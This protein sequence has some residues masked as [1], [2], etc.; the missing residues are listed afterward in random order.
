MK[1][2]NTLKIVG[3]V[4]LVGALAAFAVLNGNQSGN[5]TFLADKID[6]EVKTAFNDFINKHS[7]NFL[8]KSEYNAR[9]S[10]F[11]N[12][13]EDVKLHNAQNSSFKLGLNQFS[14]WAPTEIQNYMTLREPVDTE[15]DHTNEDEIA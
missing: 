14:D 8:T 4:A 10:L 11:R 3:S 2:N 13:Y 12:H 6:P 7:R 9:L 1:T 5:S 15:E